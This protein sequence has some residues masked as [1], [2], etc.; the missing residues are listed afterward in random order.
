LFAGVSDFSNGIP[1]K[2]ESVTES[3]RT[4]TIRYA[5][6]GLLGGFIGTVLMD[7]VLFIESILAGLPPTTNYA[8]IGAAVG[9]GARI[10]F[11]VHYLMGPGLGLLFGCITSRVGNLHIRS[12]GK[13]VLLG[14]IAGVVTIP[15]GC[16]PT[17]LLSH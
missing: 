16:V 9:G 2:P 13:G 7:V 15:L 14:L 1:E 6:L 10:G 12:V 4:T 3:N 11:A 8:V 5:Q 17:A